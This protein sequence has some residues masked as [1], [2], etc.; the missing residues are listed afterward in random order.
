PLEIRPKYKQEKKFMTYQK[1]LITIPSLEIGELT[2]TPELLPQLDFMMN[3]PEL[4]TGITRVHDE[5]Q[6]IMSASSVALL[7]TT[8][9]KK[10]VTRRRSEY[11]HPHDLFE[12]RARTYEFVRDLLNGT[13]TPDKTQVDVSW[14]CVSGNGSWRLITHQYKTFVD[15][16][17][18]AYQLS[19]NIGIEAIDPP[20]DLVLS[21]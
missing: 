7:T 21:V 3:N 6:V 18:I 10:A 19:R 4:I 16:N 15:G 5:R 11:W 20:G 9:L 13:T 2:L 12:F 14:R 17:K 8:T 1:P